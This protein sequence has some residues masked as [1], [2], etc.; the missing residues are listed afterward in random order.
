MLQWH[1][2]WQAAIR[3]RHDFFDVSCERAALCRLSCLC[4]LWHREEGRHFAVYLFVLVGHTKNSQKAGPFPVARLNW[5]CLSIV[6]SRIA[7]FTGEGPA[8]FPALPLLPPASLTCTRLET[9]R[10]RAS[11]S[12]NRSTPLRLGPTAPGSDWRPCSGGPA[13]P[14]TRRRPARATDSGGPVT[15]AGSRVGHSY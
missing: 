12:T 5:S 10:L 1:S 7:A 11:R 2:C 6:V 3:P 15:C 4:C 8:L 14:A 13:G 9:R